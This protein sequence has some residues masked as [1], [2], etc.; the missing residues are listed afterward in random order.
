MSHPSP[1]GSTTD[2]AARGLPGPADAPAL[3]VISRFRVTGEGSRRT[4]VTAA[5]KALSALSAQTGCR[6]ASLGQATDD[7]DL[8]MIRSEWV[9]VG[10]YRRALSAFDVK[11]DAVPL[12]SSAVDEPSAYEIVRHWDGDRLVE[13]SSGLAAD[14]GV[15]GLGHAAGASIP[16]V[17]P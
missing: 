11:V 13:T 7:P 9:G 6:A 14:A 3:V 15:V 2:A 17:Q 16:S 8:L 5:E 4:F 10:A 12:L 1:D